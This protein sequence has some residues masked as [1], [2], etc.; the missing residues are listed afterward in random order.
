MINNPRLRYKE[1]L[2]PALRAKNNTF[3][4]THTNQINMN[5]LFILVFTFLLATQLWGADDFAYENKTYLENIK[6]VRFHVE[7]FPSSYPVIE[8]GG[9]AQLRLSFDDISDDIRRYSYQLIHCN[10]NWDPS[11]LSPLEYIDGILQDNIRDFDFSFRTI[12]AYVH[13]TLVFPHRDMQLTKSGNYLLLITDNEDDEKPAITRRFM[14]VESLTTISGAV[15]RAMEVQKV[16][17]HQE[18]DFMVNTKRLS[19]RN[20]MQEVKATVIQNGRWDNAVSNIPPLLLS[21]EQLNFNHQGLVSFAGG[22][23]F[24]N[25]DIRSI[26]APRTA[27]SSITNEGD[28]YAMVL[29]PEN[30]RNQ[31]IFLNYFDLNGD[32]INFRDDRPILNLGDEYFQQNFERLNLEYTGDY[33]YTTF[34]LNASQPLNSDIYLF[35]GFTEFRKQAAF[36]MVYN[37]LIGAYVAKVLLKQGFYNYYY[38]TDTDAF[39]RRGEKAEEAILSETEGNFTETENDYQV[40]V[41]YRPIGGRYDQLVGSSLFNSVNS[42]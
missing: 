25:L 34:I 21:K 31:D 38:V 16:P 22:N 12:S 29:A 4:K 28:A 41:Y 24:R 6:T 7:G 1:R 42:N 11:A 33:I 36:K 8:L 15:T 10:S 9:A 13:Y 26:A 18:V 19:L 17:T 35:G 30:L 5:R 37:E 27:V 14:V 3:Q 23:E 39:G 32:F 2:A 40:L 20:P